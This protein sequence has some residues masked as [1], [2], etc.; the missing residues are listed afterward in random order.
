[1]VLRI[2]QE[3][4]ASVSQADIEALLATVASNVSN[5]EAG[6]FGPDSLSWRINR[7]SALFLGAGRA[8]L[9]QLAH[10]WVTASLAEH[11]SVMDRPHSAFPQHVSH[12][13]HDDLRFAPAG[14]GRLTPPA[15]SRTPGFKAKCRRTSRNG[16]AA[17]ATKPTRSA[18]CDGFSL[19]LLRAPSWPTT[20]HCRRYRQRS[21]NTIMPSAK[22]WP[23]SSAFPRGAARELGSFRGLQPEYARL[24]RTWRQRNRPANGAQPAPRR[25]IVGTA[26]ILVSRAYY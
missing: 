2:G 15:C 17:R 3:S 9:L 8:A 6:I 25:G 1:M 12:R 4:P 10:P 19:R 20:A 18:R 5:A 23:D 24:R 26:A 14:V 13:V 22:R 7:E 11:S 16:S 21:A